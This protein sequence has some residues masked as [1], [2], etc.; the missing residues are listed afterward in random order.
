MGEEARGSAWGVRGG[1]RLSQELPPADSARPVQALWLS[2]P[3]VLTAHLLSLPLRLPALSVK[4]PFGPRPL[5]E[6]VVG[7]ERAQKAQG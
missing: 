7:I 5:G 6:P 2:I 3:S 1:A 4:V